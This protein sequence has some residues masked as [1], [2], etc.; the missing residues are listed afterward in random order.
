MWLP[1]SRDSDFLTWNGDGGPKKENQ[2]FHSRFGWEQRVVC[3]N[4]KQERLG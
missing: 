1:D 3:Y 4:E 2:G